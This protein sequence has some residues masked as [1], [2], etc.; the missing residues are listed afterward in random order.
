MDDNDTKEERYRG[1]NQP[2]KQQSDRR[3]FVEYPTIGQSMNDLDVRLYAMLLQLLSCLNR[4]PITTTAATTITVTTQISNSFRI[5]FL[6]RSRGTLI[7]A[8]LRLY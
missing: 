6:K 3:P 5:A 8:H 2:T 1:A 4:L 7:S